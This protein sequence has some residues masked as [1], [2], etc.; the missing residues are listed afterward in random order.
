MLERF[1][2]RA[3]KAISSA[4]TEAGN[5]NHSLVDT[6]HLLLGLLNDSQSVAVNVLRQMNIDYATVRVKVLNLVVPGKNPH[7]SKEIPFTPRAKKVLELAIDEAKRLDHNYVGTEHL[8]L[9]LIR[10]TE[11]IAYQALHELGVDVPTVVLELDVLDAKKPACWGRPVTCDHKIEASQLEA[12]QS[13]KN[14][15]LL[16]KYKKLLQELRTLTIKQSQ[17]TQE[18]LTLFLKGDNDGML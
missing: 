12:S 16:E 15:Q 1:T 9:G 14:Q 18:M 13:L 10:E 8:L 17:I 3:R 2:D 11:G 4:K 7:N 6:E 5:L